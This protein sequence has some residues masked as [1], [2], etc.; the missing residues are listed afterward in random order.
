MELHPDGQKKSLEPRVVR[1]AK[2]FR[3]VKLEERI[4]PTASAP[5]SYWCTVTC[6]PC[7]AYT[8]HKCFK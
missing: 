7:F 1:K 4:A 6:R 8:A 2:R 3:I 5:R